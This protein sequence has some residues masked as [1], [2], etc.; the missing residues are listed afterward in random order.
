MLLTSLLIPNGVGPGS[1]I[2]TIVV[3]ML[4]IVSTSRSDVN[5]RCKICSFTQVK[6]IR[7]TK[8]NASSLGGDNTFVLLYV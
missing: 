2:L 1:I 5:W 3:A 6:C 7:N 8:N 4:S